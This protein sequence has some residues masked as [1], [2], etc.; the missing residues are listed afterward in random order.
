[1]IAHDR[2]KGGGSGHLVAP[3]LQDAVLERSTGVL[4]GRL[5]VPQ[6]LPVFAGH[7]PS[8]A[9]VPGVVQLGWVVELIRRYGLTSE[10]FSGVSFVKF[11]RILRPAFEFEACFTPRRALGEIEFE[12]TS[13]HAVVSCGR[14]LFGECG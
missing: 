3:E 10:P 11:R 12:F 13:Q 7:F 14:L 1:M 2:G 5:Q 4:T 6:E 8:V 9:I